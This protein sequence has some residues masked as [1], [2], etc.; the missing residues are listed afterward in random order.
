MSPFSE[1]HRVTMAVGRDPS[2]ETAVREFAAAIS[3]IYLKGDTKTTVA[4]AVT[5]FQQAVAIE[6]RTQFLEE[7]RRITAF[8]TTP[9][10]DT[11]K[12]ASYAPEAVDKLIHSRVQQTAIDIL[13]LIDHGDTVNQGY[14]L[15]PVGELEEDDPRLTRDIAGE[16]A[17]TYFDA[18]NN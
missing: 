4:E 12:Q 2:N 8:Q 10:F 5:N 16:L 9:V 15:I 13:S 1:A 6:G 14:H 17:T 3:E 7:V 18:I 11:D